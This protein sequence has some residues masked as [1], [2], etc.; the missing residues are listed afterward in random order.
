MGFDGHDVLDK[1]RFLPAVMIM[2]GI[3]VH[4]LEPHCQPF[5]LLFEQAGNAQHRVAP[6]IAGDPVQF[7]AVVCPDDAVVVNQV[8]DHIPGIEPGMD[9]RVGTAPKIAGQDK[10]VGDPV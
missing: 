1:E 7:A 9:E 6:F 5:G 10:G 4:L 3:R 2:G 8:I